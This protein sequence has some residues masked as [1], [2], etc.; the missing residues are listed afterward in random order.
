[1]KLRARSF[2]EPDASRLQE[3]V[4][5]KPGSWLA[6]G[7]FLILLA[8]R[9]HARGERRGTALHVQAVKAVKPHGG[10]ARIRAVRHCAGCVF[11]EV[12]EDVDEGVSHLARACQRAP[13]PAVRPERAAAVQELV[14][15]AREPSFEAVDPRREGAALRGFHDEVHVVGLH[16]VV[17]DAEAIR[18]VVRGA[19]DGDADRGVEELRTKGAETG[20]E[21]DVHWVP[22]V[23][24]GARAVRCF[25]MGA[26]L[27]TGVPS[28]ATPG[29]FERELELLLEP[30]ASHLE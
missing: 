30:A 21:R 18:R 20:S 15:V 7:H 1:M 27:S 24:P 28:L 9:P 2:V 13:V 17:D 29:G 4:A 3:T 8:E 25:G 22:E 6:D 11:S 10:R 14:D 23:V 16:G 26:G 12:G 5:Q 19:G